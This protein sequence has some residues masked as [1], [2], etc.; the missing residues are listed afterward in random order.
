M[1]VV[2]PFDAPSVAVSEQVRCFL[3]G[4]CGP[5][6]DKNQAWVCGAGDA[7]VILLHAKCAERLAVDLIGDSREVML[8]TGRPR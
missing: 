1:G 3:C 8:K 4:E 6:I 7:N 5:K 2:Y